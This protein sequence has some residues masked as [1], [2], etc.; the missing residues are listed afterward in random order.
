MV[1]NQRDKLSGFA[2]AIQPDDN[3]FVQ[4]NVATDLIAG[5]TPDVGDETVSTADPTQTGSIF[6]QPSILLGEFGT[7]SINIPLRGYG[8]GAPPAANAWPTGKLLQACGFTELRRAAD[9]VSANLV[10]GSTTTALNL[11]ATESAVDD[12]LIGLPIQHAGIGAANRGFTLIRDYIGAAKT[13]LLAE[14]LGGAPAAGTPYIFP[15]G[16]SYI[17]GTLNTPPPKL[18]FSVWRGNKRFDYYKAAVTGWS[19]DVPVANEA[20]Q[21]FPSL[22]IQL[23]GTFYAEAPQTSPAVPSSILGIP[24][25]PAR[26]GKFF[27]DRIMLGHAGVKY[28]VTAE[29]GAASNQ[30]QDYGQDSYDIL[31]ASRSVDLDLNQMDVTDFDLRARVTN[32]TNLPIL[33]TW[34][35]G[36]GNR[37]G[38]LVPNARLDPFKPGGRNGYVAVTGKANPT[39]VDKSCAL[40]FW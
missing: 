21:S 10:A 20:N 12:A 24:V 35:L 5:T 33:S 16:L 2:V 32:Q 29:S 14:T 22:Q 37:I 4:P 34:G 27:L 38:L 7:C 18:S 31:S 6:D 28:D 3:T 39:D 23:K 1:W 26:G 11:A 8:V 19:I 30:N 40:S 9:S 15:A 13:A 25:P 17:L 36:V